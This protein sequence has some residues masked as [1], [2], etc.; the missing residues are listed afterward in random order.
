VLA[1]P[2]PVPVDVA[3][4]PFLFG[5]CV[6]EPVPLAVLVPFGPAAVLLAV[7]DCG[8]VP[9]LVVEAALVPFDGDVVVAGAVIVFVDAAPPSAGAAALPVPFDGADR[10]PGVVVQ[11]RTTEAFTVYVSRGDTM[12][13]A[14]TK[15]PICTSASESVGAM[16]VSAAVR[17]VHVPPQ[18]PS[19][20]VDV[21]TDSTTPRMS[22]VPSRS[23]S[24]TIGMGASAG[25]D[26]INGAVNV[27]D[28]ESGMPR[29]PLPD[30]PV[31]LDV[32][33]VPVLVALAVGVL[34]PVEAESVLLAAVIAVPVADAAFALPAALIAFSTGAL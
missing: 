27:S 31:S 11:S 9:P 10:T 30:A 5:G 16:S 12:P 34:V 1:A 23:I 26:V 22:A 15:S 3:L 20:S 21:P 24:T 32:A 13:R 8:A 7:I 6:L 17:M 19:V 14:P 4:E 29:A 28:T 18:V 25:S 2:T 33:V